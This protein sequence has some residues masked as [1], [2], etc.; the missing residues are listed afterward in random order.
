[1]GVGTL[2]GMRDEARYSR[3]PTDPHAFTASFDRFY[4]RTARAYDVAVKLLPVWRRWLRHTLPHLRGPR[5]LEVS[6]GTGWLLT[7]F[8][9]QHDAFGLDRNARMVTIARRNLDRAGVSAGL[10]Q[11][12]VAALPYRDG[13]FDTVVT[14]MAFSGF[15]DGAQA[16]REM[17]RVLRP[18]GRLVI[19]DVAHPHDRNVLGTALVRMWR[20]SGDLIRDLPALLDRAGF[21]ASDREIGGWGSVH[22]YVA[23]SARP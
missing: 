10:V 11:G 23:R 3:E 14:T 19:V 8:A 1:V 15:P 17:G 5:V 4:T 12:D 20:R 6:F 16:L 7:R 2:R 13:S 22:L 9:D 18:Q 21:A